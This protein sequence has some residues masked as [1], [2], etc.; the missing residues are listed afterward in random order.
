VTE[1]SPPLSN[2]TAGAAQLVPHSPLDG[3]ALRFDF[4]ALQVGIAEYDAGPTGCTV[5]AF[6]NG[7]EA[8]VDARGGAVG[9][10]MGKD[11]WIHAICFAGGSVYGLEA[12][13]GVS[14]ELL[15]Q[16]GFSARWDQIAVVRGAIIYDFGPRENTIYPDKALGRAALRAARPGMFPL[17]PRGAGR[18][19]TVGKWALRG[20]RGEPAGQGGAMRQVG[21]VKV[22]VFTVVNAVGAL[23]DR[24][25]RV[26]RGFLDPRTGRRRHP[27][28]VAGNVPSTGAEVPSGGA[29][30]HGNTTLTLLVTNADLPTRSLRQL[31]RQV[32]GSMARAIQPFHTVFDGDVLFAVTTREVEPPDLDYLEL[33]TAASE[34]AWDAVLSSYQD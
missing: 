3:P 9:T 31:G 11:G 10:I 4:P 5:F 21:E 17:G 26:V 29:P 16:R 7:A 8:V 28:E 19:A 33:A 27:A 24:S 13:T 32:H 23:V 30:A 25:G 20:L 18:S 12:A 15:A 1:A 6:P 22:A 34:L 14:A 2:D